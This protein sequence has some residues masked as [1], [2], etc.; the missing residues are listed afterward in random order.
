MH[1]LPDGWGPPEV[2]ADAIVVDGL[3]LHRA[4]IAAT[5]PWGEEITGSAAGSSD[6]AFRRGWFELLERAS[7]VDAIR[8]GD[9][10]PLRS[11]DGIS[12][13]VIAATDLFPESDEPERWR[14]ARSSGVALHATWTEAC[15]RALWELVERDRI[16][17]SWCGELTPRLLAWDPG[18]S[19]VAPTSSYDWEAHAFDVPEPARFGAGSSTVGVFGFPRRAGVP[20]VVG[21]AARPSVDEALLAAVDEASQLLAFLWGEELPAA[22]PALGPTA[23][24]H[25]EHLLWPESARSL[26]AWLGG[27]HTR[28]RAGPTSPVPDAPAEV[29]FADL[30]PTWL[31]GGLRVAK[32]VCAAALPLAF[33]DAPFTGHLPPELRAHPV[34]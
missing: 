17:R 30:T 13:G 1:P 24:H 10:V 26:R 20:L 32:A 25:L 5:S 12:Q 27:Q 31:D 19:V 14:Y 28:W 9:A 6:A 4:G 16:L 11:R 18:A 8:A 21:Y 3:P 33:G 15:N 23:M 22:R 2:L 7:T 29:S 34:P